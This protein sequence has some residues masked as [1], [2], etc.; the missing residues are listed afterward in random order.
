MITGYP[1]VSRQ[2][3]G[4]HLRL[5]RHVASEQQPQEGLRHGLAALDVGGK[6]LLA[7]GDGQPAKAD[8]LRM[9][10]IRKRVDLR[11]TCMHARTPFEPVRAARAQRNGALLISVLT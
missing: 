11:V 10:H 1:S 8:A 5:R 6:L 3:C 9:Q 4:R 2:K 7:V